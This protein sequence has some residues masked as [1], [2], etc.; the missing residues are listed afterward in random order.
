M[1]RLVLLLVL[2]LNLNAFAQE[3]EY[4]I[5]VKDIETLM[6]IEN[7]TVLIMKTKQT[8]ITNKDGKVTFL[9]N[10]ASN[11]QVSDTD[12][13]KLTLRWVSLKEDQFVVYL[14]SSHNKLDEIVVSNENPQKTL[15]KIVSNSRQK[16]A[17]S[18]RLKVYVREFFMLNNKYSYYNDGLVN[19]QFS[20]S[21]KKATTTLLVEQNRSYGLLEKDISADLMGYNL[22]NIMENYSNLKYFDPLLDSKTKKEYSFTT[23]G[24]PNNKNYYIMSVTPLDNSKTALD[25]YEII[26]DPEKKLIVEFS[27]IIVPANLA[28]IQENEQIGS[29]N[30]TKSSVRVNYRIDGLD[31]Y[32]LTANEEIGYD[33]VLKEEI[34]NI[35]VRNSFIT[36]NFNRQNFT[37][38]ESDVFKEKSLFNKKNKVL[39]KY[40]DISG[41]TATDEEKGI[42]DSLEFKL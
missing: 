29:Q 38:K 25:T 40:W 18:Y 33:L 17:S 30:I 23:K 9:L 1:S 16:L 26:Y 14:K 5:I 13:E 42:I 34:K 27:V 31:Y 32:L 35:Q 6:P 41:F 8:L 4:S 39:T 20:V 28:E 2:F 37:Y 24:H 7:A 15:Q 11:V 10:G 21:Q 3:Q 22:N 36:T 19:F 12:Y